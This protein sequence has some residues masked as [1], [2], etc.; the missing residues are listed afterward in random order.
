MEEAEHPA[1]VSK[2]CCCHP[3]WVKS[4]AIQVVEVLQPSWA[5]KLILLLLKSHRN[6][7]SRQSYY[8]WPGRV[9]IVS[10]V[11]MLRAIIGHSRRPKLGTRVLFL[12]ASTPGIR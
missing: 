10:S 12:H 6:S 3:V 2:S 7:S 8:I 11:Y 9:W 4:S 5:T 1:S